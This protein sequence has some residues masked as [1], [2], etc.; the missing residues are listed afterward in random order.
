M[1]G[2]V[3]DATTENGS[4][5]ESGD[6]MFSEPSVA[7]GEVPHLLSLL[8]QTYGSPALCVTTV[9]EVLKHPVATLFPEDGS[10][11]CRHC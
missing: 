10:R 6:L 8:D 3:H 7:K 2:I 1:K 4:S 5:F 11:R 9:L